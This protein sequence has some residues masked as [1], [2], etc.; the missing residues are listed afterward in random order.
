MVLEYYYGMG[1]PLGSAVVVG[2]RGKTRLN[3]CQPGVQSGTPIYEMKRLG[4]A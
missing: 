3:P 2:V 4:L 1:G